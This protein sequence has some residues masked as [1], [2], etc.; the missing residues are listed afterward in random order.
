MA[1]DGNFT[2]YVPSPLAYGFDDVVKELG[3]FHGTTKHHEELINDVRDGEIDLVILGTC[4]IEFV[5]L[6][7]PQISCLLKFHPPLLVACVIGETSCWQ[8]GMPGV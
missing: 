2:T 8:L 6:F 3:L 4:E 5:V 1:D 7:S